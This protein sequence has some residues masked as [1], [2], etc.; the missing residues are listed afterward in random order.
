MAQV[1]PTR[2]P[3][4]RSLAPARDSAMAMARS[5]SLD[6]DLMLTIILL[7]FS[8]SMRLPEVARPGHP[9]PEQR[10]QGGPHA[11]LEVVVEMR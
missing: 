5:S 2:G 7:L 3:V 8:G 1:R 4:C 9:V 6:T 11:E 10:R